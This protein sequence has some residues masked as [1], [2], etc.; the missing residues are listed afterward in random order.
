MTTTPDTLFEEAESLEAV[1]AKATWKPYPEYRDSGVEWLQ[2]IPSHWTVER[3]KWSA[4]A[5]RNGIWGRE[6][7]GV[8]DIPCVRVADFHRDQLRVDMEDPTMRAVTPKERR[9]RVLMNGDLLL[10]KSGGGDL[11]PVGAVMLYDHKAEAVCSNFIARVVIAPG[12][13]PRFVAYLHAHLYSS[14]VNTRAIKQTTGIQNLDSSVYF[15]TRAAWPTLPEQQAIVTFLDRK[16]REI[17]E[18][19]EKKR[20]LIELLQ[21]QRTALISHA[22]TKGLNPDASMKP[23]GVEWLGDVPEHWEVK[24]L[25]YA[26]TFQRGHDLPLDARSPGDVPIVTSAGESAWHDTAVAPG[27]AIVTGRYG[28]I[29]VFHLIEHPFWPLNTT[30]YTIDLRGNRPRFLWYM[31]HLLSPVFLSEA[32]KS[33][34][35]GVDRNDLH[36]VAVAVPPAEEQEAIEQ[37]LDQ[38]MLHILGVIESTDKAALMLVEY[39]QAM[40]SAAVTGKIDVRDANARQELP[41]G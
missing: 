12:F 17:D 8:D 11:Q 32:G 3:I 41:D 4:A 29:G 13:E 26:A 34:V 33:A 27:P 16:T 6:P 39:R 36:P 35:P 22:V 30:L 9:G 20:R 18:L 1:T 37:Y 24:Q 7:D 21:E 2:A 28:T 15:D 38:A 5:V 23:S 31:L 10:E 25:K 40:I 19:I 14:R